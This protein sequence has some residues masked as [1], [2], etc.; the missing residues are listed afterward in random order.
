MITR[1]RAASTHDYP[2][3]ILKFAYAPAFDALAFIVTTNSY[4]LEMGIMSDEAKNEKAT[5]FESEDIS[6]IAQCLGLA[7]VGTDGEFL[8]FDTLEKNGARQRD[9]AV[10]FDSAKKILE[11][12]DRGGRR[13]EEAEGWLDPDRG[14]AEFEVR[15]QGLGAMRPS[16]IEKFEFDTRPC[17]HEHTAEPPLAYEESRQY[18]SAVIRVTSSDGSTCIEISPNT[19][20]CP[21]LIPL[22][23][24]SKGRTRTHATLKV[25]LAGATEQVEL[26]RR[27]RELAN[28]FL[29]ELNARHRTVYSL[30]PKVEVPSYRR[31]GV[32]I[33]HSVR[34]PRTP[35]PD[36]VAALFSIPSDFAMR[37]NFTLFYLSYYQILEHYFPA[38]HRRDSVK[39]VRRILR[40][41]DFDEEKDASVLKILNSV[42]RSHGASEA[43][44]LRTLIEECVPE[45]KLQEF[46]ALDHGGHFDRNGPISGVSAVNPKSGEPLASQVAKRIYKLR[47]RIV[48]AKD[49]VRY[50][51]S[52]VLLPL[53]HEA[54]KLYPDIELVR[55]LAIEAIVDNR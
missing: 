11:S 43:D 39:K 15:M 22:G 30:R 31:R 19:L 32:S 6:R 1:A 5:P 34:F 27:S 46:F 50:A 16:S 33:S 13:M 38:V 28:S 21:P 36:N 35:V 53:S 51:E 10:H 17:P 26:E 41:L 18:V 45:G 37:G 40:S 25:F 55:L 8:I 54:M 9:A 49:D 14:F 24:E 12:I 42:E 2:Y 23:A 20:L 44:Q 48:H 47:N 4:T 52:K 7:H 3:D 29:F